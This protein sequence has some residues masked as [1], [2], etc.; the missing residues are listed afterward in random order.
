MIVLAGG[1][2]RRMGGADKTA[3]EVGGRSL[4]DHVLASWPTDASMVVVG[5]RRQVT[6][7]VE[8]CREL[9]PGSGPLSGLAAGLARLDTELVA[10]AAGDAPMVGQGVPALLAAASRS[11]AA[12]G[13]G[14]RAVSPDG[15][16]QT[17][18]C[19][20]LR[21]A[22]VAALP[23]TVCGGALWPVLDRLDLAHVVMDDDTLHDVDTPEDLTRVHQLWSDEQGDDDE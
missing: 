6:R 1:S 2:S 7:P 17:M 3:L 14:A 19:C 23:T 5:P 20:A 22:L 9:P 4:L 18:P 8:W 10:L 11:I 15:R 13:Q 12:G 16:L 21:T